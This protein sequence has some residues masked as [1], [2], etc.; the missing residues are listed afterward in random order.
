MLECEIVDNGLTPTPVL[1]ATTPISIDNLPHVV[2][3]DIVVAASD[4]VMTG[5]SVVGSKSGALL[6]YVR[7]HPQWTAPGWVHAH[8]V[9]T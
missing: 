1:D 5:C 7:A 6:G 8:L 4:L 2:G 9:A 3:F